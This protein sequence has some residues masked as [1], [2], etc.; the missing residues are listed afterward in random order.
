MLDWLFGNSNATPSMP[1]RT[2]TPDPAPR[3]TPLDL[4]RPLS[5]P[6][7]DDVAQARQADASYGDPAAA[8]VQPA[9][10]PPALHYALPP[11]PRNW[12]AS[13][14][15]PAPPPQQPP[16]SGMVA[17]PTSFMTLR[18]AFDNI[19]DK[20][21]HGV[22]LAPT[23]PPVADNLMAG[24]LASR[25]SALAALGFDPHNMVVGNI[26]PE[27]LSLGGEYDPT[28]DTIATTGIYPSTTVH[29]SMHR[30]I[31]KLR[32]ARMLPQAFPNVSEEMAVRAQMQRNYGLVEQGRGDVGDQQ[33]AG[34]TR[35]NQKMPTL[36]DALEKAAQELYAR[37][38]AHG[39]R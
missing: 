26:P 34:G 33:V 8:F 35:M 2:P 28:T 24:Y 38:H 39:P 5:Y 31:Q 29:E 7:L 17:S 16:Y 27:K 13:G 25:R 11:N 12:T 6:G 14:A 32:D 21:P 10:Q 1:P 15:P 36:M 18:D 30:G 37:M 22:P 3:I 20:Q 4:P 23:S 9:P 19:D